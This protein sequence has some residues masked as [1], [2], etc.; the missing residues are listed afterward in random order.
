MTEEEYEDKEIFASNVFDNGGEV[1]YF[2]INEHECLEMSINNPCGSGVTEL[3]MT[4]EEA[5][6]FTEDEAVIEDQYVYDMVMQ[7][8]CQSILGL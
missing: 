6:L 4:S 2:R 7:E 5:I 3:L 1:V 8:A